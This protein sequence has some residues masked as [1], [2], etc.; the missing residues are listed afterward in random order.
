MYGDAVGVVEEDAKRMLLTGCKVQWKSHSLQ[1]ARETR[2]N[3]TD[4]NS[5]PQAGAAASRTQARSFREV[6]TSDQIHA[7]ICSCFI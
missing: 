2:T 4:P 3:M 6:P 7:S 5:M 1:S